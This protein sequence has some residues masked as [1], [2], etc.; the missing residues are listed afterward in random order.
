MDL[1][2]STDPAYS[3]RNSSSAICFSARSS[4]KFRFASQ[5]PVHPPRKIGECTVATYLPPPSLHTNTSS[6]SD[7][8]QLLVSEN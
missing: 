4:T 3:R 8:N 1:Q 2:K 7:D 5:A 6:S